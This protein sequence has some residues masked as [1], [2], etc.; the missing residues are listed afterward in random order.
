M[1]AEFA[2]PMGRTHT[3]SSRGEC[4]LRR[5]LCLAAL[6]LLLAVSPMLFAQ[7]TEGNITGTVT[8]SDGALVPNATVTVIN[9]GTHFT[10]V[11]QAD[12][13]GTYVVTALNPG[14]Y[15]IKIA[16]PGFSELQDSGVNLAAQQTVRI[17]GQLKVSGTSSTVT[18]T[19]QA[20]V[21][22]LEMPS[23]SST[24]TSEALNDTSSNLLGTSDST[25]DSGLL[26]YTTLLP[27]G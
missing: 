11:V 17:D 12:A 13:N 5:L 6:V 19:A 18:V 10:R 25:G 2:Q 15:T 22:N 23:I 27:G 8:A 14:S 24:V 16:A 9:D 4:R 3:S 7:G 21:I 1:T 20:P 26:F